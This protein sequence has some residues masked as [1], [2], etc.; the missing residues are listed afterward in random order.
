[1]ANGPQQAS[2][3]S[4]PGSNTSSM[5]SELVSP[6]TGGPGDGHP[7]DTAPNFEQM[8]GEVA[9]SNRRLEGQNQELSQGLSH[10]KKDV[11]GSRAFQERIMQAVNPDAAKQEVSGFDQKISEIDEQIEYWAQYGF[12]EEGKKIKHTVLN[13]VQNLELQRALEIEKETNNRERQAMKAQLE[14]LSNPQLS[15]D[16]QMY[17]NMDNMV[18]SVLDK[19][20]PGK[21]YAGAHEAQRQAI[22]GLAVQYLNEIKTKHPDFLQKMR[23]DNREVAKFIN[24]VIESTLPPSIINRLKEDKIQSEPITTQEIL[25]QI[26]VARSTIE[27]PDLRAETITL[28]R[29]KFWE[30]DW[31]NN[32]KR[33]G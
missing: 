22:Q 27:D 25:K 28:L 9:E 33:R 26:Q 14:A 4:S 5:Y 10:L 13:K 29:Q 31:A 7:I 1:M 18:L 16:R 30:I 8:F 21:Q 2:Q 20:Y 32:R 15:I 19:L 17:A 23:R 24:R 11:E 6:P 3:Q 12:T